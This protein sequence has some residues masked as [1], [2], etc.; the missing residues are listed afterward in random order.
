MVPLDIAD[1]FAPPNLAV[2]LNR[3]VSPRLRDG[4]AAAVNLHADYW[5]RR[6]P[7]PLVDEVPCRRRYRVVRCFPSERMVFSAM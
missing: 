1:R 4:V 7:A 6:P 3:I 2:A 5:P